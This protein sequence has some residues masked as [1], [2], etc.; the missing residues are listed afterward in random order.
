M[1]AHRLALGLLAC[2]STAIPAFAADPIVIN[3]ETAVPL[4]ADQ[5]ANRFP[6]WEE[7]GIVFTLAHEP[8]QSKGKGL[9]MFFTHLATGHKGLVSALA[10][11]AIPVRATLP[12]PASEVTVTFWGS[13]VTPAILEAFDREG[14]LLHRATLPAPP[15]RKAPGDPVPFFPLT[16]KAANIAA[17]QFSGPRP[18]EFLAADE[19]RITPATQ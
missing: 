9:L 4:G 16:V 13:T 3:F 14:K 11:E 5:K 12:A 17:I 10:T 7:K 18:G 1:T 2:L 15:P 19:L 8:K 6:R